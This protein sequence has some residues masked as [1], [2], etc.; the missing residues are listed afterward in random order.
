MG[1]FENLNVDAISNL[2]A[3]V[4]NNNILARLSL[5]DAVRTSVLSREWRYKWTFIPEIVFG[6]EFGRA[7]LRKH[8]ERIIDQVLSRHQGPINKFVLEEDLI[9]AL[10]KLALM[11]ITGFFYY[12]I[13]KSRTSLFPAIFEGFISQCVLLESVNL[14]ECTELDSLEVEGPS[15]RFFTFRGV[16]KSI[17]FKNSPVLAQVSL[18][19]PVQKTREI[20]LS[21]CIKYFA[22]LPKLEKLYLHEGLLKPLILRQ[23]S[24]RDFI[25]VL[26]STKMDESPSNTTG[27]SDVLSSQITVT[28]LQHQ[29]ISVKLSDSNYLVWKQQV[30]AAVT[31]LGLESYLTGSMEVPSKL[32]R[33]PVT[34]KT[35]FNPAYQ[36]YKR[37]DQLLISWLLSSLSESVLVLMV[38]L[39]TCQEMWATLEANFAAQSSAKTMQYKVQLQTMKKGNLSMREYLNKIKI[40]CDNLAASGYKIEDFDQVLHALTGLGNEYDPV[41]VTITSNPEKWTFKD[42]SALLLSFEAR[43]DSANLITEDGNVPMVNVATHA[44]PRRN[45]TAGNFNTNRGRGSFNNRGGRRGSSRGR[46]GRMFGGR[47]TCQICGYSNHTADNVSP[48]TS[49]LYNSKNTDDNPCQQ[50]TPVPSSVSSSSQPHTASKDTYDTIP[51][52]VELPALEEPSQT[53]IMPQIESVVPNTHPMQTRGKTGGVPNRFPDSFSSLIVVDLSMYLDSIVEV[54]SFL[55]LIRSSPKLQMLRVTLCVYRIDGAVTELLR[56]QETPDRYLNQ[57]RRVEIEVYTYADPLKEFAR[58]VLACAAR[59]EEMVIYDPKPRFS[60]GSLLNLTNELNRLPRASPS[61]VIAIRSSIIFF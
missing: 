5:R 60:R 31:G 11:L 26:V 57:L 1:S 59:L 55:C 44:Q 48:L 41:V 9:L 51:L 30:L 43:V 56:A 16:F 35:S 61:A 25:L 53:N 20:Q 50:T 36:A 8:I 52:A 47:L 10:V 54:A 17:R 24:Q 29:L 6:Y 21:N 12:R 23:V 27:S 49:S 18:Y 58:Y 15:L 2:P 28:Q 14:D 7:F 19:T 40:C 46:G 33:D 38:G 45:N 32:I 13:A 3:D 37:Q 22:L 39:T 42:A 34:K 4:I